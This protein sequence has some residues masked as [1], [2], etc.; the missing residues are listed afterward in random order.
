MYR[1]YHN[2]NVIYTERG[3]GKIYYAVNLE[4]EQLCLTLPL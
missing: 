2:F 1:H 3:V 4:Q